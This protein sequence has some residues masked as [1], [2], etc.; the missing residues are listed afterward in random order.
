MRYFLIYDASHVIAIH[1]TMH[2]ALACYRTV[3]QD[4]PH[5]VLKE[6]ET[7]SYGVVTYERRVLIHGPASVDICVE[8]LSA[9]ESPSETVIIRKDTFSLSP[10]FM[11]E[12]GS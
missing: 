1:K 7:S 12:G 9:G 5:L 4:T 10:D 2:S 3:L 6:V 11:R 8:D